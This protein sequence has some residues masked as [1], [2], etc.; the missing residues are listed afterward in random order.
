MVGLSGNCFAHKRLHRQSRGPWNS[1]ELLPVFFLR[2]ANIELPL[3]WKDV[4]GGNVP[5]VL[6]TKN[7][8][9]EDIKSEEKSKT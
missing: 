4:T 6:C 7:E 8:R 5:I 2:R 9:K 1:S 3:K